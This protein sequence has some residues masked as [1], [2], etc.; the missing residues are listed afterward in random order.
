MSETILNNQPGD[1]TLE[2]Q[3]AVVNKTTQINQKP[4]FFVIRATGHATQMMPDI[5]VQEYGRMLRI[6]N[7]GKCRMTLKTYSGTT[8]N[9]FTGDLINDGGPGFMDFMADPDYGAWRIVG[10]SGNWTLGSNGVVLDIQNATSYDAKSLIPNFFSKQRLPGLDDFTGGVHPSL[11]RFTNELL[12]RGCGDV[13]IERTPILLRDVDDNFTVS[14]LGSTMFNAMF[15]DIVI[16]FVPHL[17]DG[18]KTIIAGTINPGSWVL[19]YNPVTEILKLE[20]SYFQ[21]FQFSTPLHPDSD[22]VVRLRFTALLKHTSGT[23]YPNAMIFVNG[24]RV[25]NRIAWLRNTWNADC[26]TF[27]SSINPNTWEI[28]I[29]RYAS[30]R[31][32]M[33]Y[34]WDKMSDTLYS[35]PTPNTYMMF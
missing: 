19:K 1:T 30:I 31:D 7:E 21:D 28:M 5:A 29:H 34:N 9:D 10:N 4:L 13:I 6:V 18:E 2:V 35:N 22:G 15:T 32:A 12:E 23:D 16:S 33:P 20:S 27:I 25:L 11:C 24:K 14:G 26:Y 8:I 3:G 17:G